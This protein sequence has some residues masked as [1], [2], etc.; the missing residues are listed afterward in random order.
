VKLKT[1][2]LT[3]RVGSEIK[4]DVS[5]LL[6]GSAAS[7][8]RSLLELRGV[9]IV[10]GVNLD[11]D[12]L[13]EF[14][15]TLGT[16][17]QDQKEGGTGVFKVTF[18][19]TEN[20]TGLQY[21]D[22]TKYWHMDRVDLDVP[23]LASILTPRVL[24]PTGGETEFANTY[25]AYQDLPESE[26]KYL[27]T[28][29]VVHTFEAQLKNWRDFPPKTQPLV[30]Q[31]RSGR[32]SLAIGIHASPIIGIDRQQSDEILSRLMHWAT[33]PEYVYRHA[34]EMGDLL[35][36][37]NTGTMHRAMP[38]DRCSGRRLHRATLVGEEPLSRRQPASQVTI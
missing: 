38:F 25:A 22:G 11:D 16:L 17:S 2:E 18:D 33:R 3:P 14:S 4:I 7:E 9:V 5:T 30:W 26:K 23:P 36:W 1:E 34:W 8:I 37:D 19:E 35:I 24:A 20:P 29:D 27:D 10:R 31:H 12:Q 6:S 21:L 13:I 28:L 15:K 32:K